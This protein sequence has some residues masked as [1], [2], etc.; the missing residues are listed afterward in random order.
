M[1]IFKTGDRVLITL[2]AGAGWIS[3]S[4]F[5]TPATVLLASDNGRS[6]MLGFEAMIGGYVGLMPV[7]WSD[8]FGEFCELIAGRTIKVDEF[9]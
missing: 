2:P 8:D 9:L 5:K 7:L 1:H 6:L 3:D 4:G